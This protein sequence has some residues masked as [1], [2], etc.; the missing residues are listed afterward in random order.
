MIDLYRVRKVI[1]WLIFDEKIINEKDLALKLNYQKSYLSQVLNGKVPLAD[2]FIDGLL[3]MDQRIS[4][5]W[6]ETGFGSMFKDTG[7]RAA[8][9]QN[10]RVTAPLIS[11][12][13]YEG[14]MNN[15]NNEE[16]LKA[17]PRYVSARNYIQD[18]YVAFEVSDDGMD[19]K[20]SCAFLQGDI[21][22]CREID[23][24]GWKKDMRL[25]QVYVTVNTENEILISEII[26][27]DEESQ[28]IVCH[29]WN[30]DD[31][32]QPDGLVKLQNILKV[33]LV[34]EISRSLRKQ[35]CS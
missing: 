12:Y 20:T 24:D 1:K 13:A 16:F 23:L 28:T 33:F 19:D 26:R 10:S 32:Y 5:Y 29:Q 11:Q 35:V 22:L 31:E 18:N 27:K 8:I 14:Y 6:L 15:L 21:L 9:N 3:S 4:R 25:P 2:K 30:P 17:Q 34:K 7:L